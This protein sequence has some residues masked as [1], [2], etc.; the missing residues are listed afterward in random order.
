MSLRDWFAGNID[1]GDINFPDFTSAADWMG[2]DPPDATD[3]ASLL[4]FSFKLEAF[5]RYKKADAMLEARE[6]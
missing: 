2:I 6:D 3:F 5:I 4:E 1:V